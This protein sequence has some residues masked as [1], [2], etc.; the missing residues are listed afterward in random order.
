VARSA[1]KESSQHDGPHILVIEDDAD[2]RTLIGM[3]LMDE[4]YQVEQ[5]PDGLFAFE[6]ISHSHPRMILLDM[7]MPGMNGWE[8]LRRY[9]ELYGR[10]AHVLVITAA[11]DTSSPPPGVDADS[12]LSKPFELAELLDRVAEAVRPGHVR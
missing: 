5:A 10:R 7:K 9:R 4:G 11:H 1:E 2:I 6:L 8:F 3:A 12:Y